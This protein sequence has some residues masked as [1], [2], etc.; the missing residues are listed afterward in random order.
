MISL[1]VLIVVAHGAALAVL[2]G[3]SWE[4]VAVSTIINW[5]SIFA[6]AF[7][8]GGLAVAEKAA[9]A[10]ATPLDDVFIR[11]VRKSVEHDLDEKEE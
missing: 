1:G 3:V 11:E 8:R 2:D 4:T 7:V 10:T 5:L 9:E 6:V